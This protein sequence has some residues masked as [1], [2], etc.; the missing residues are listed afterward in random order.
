ML[1]WFYVCFSTVLFPLNFYLS[2]ATIYKLLSLGLKGDSPFYATSWLI[3][4]LEIHVILG[5]SETGKLF[6]SDTYKGGN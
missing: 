1:H 4:Q 6:Y 3:H 5:D 2:Q